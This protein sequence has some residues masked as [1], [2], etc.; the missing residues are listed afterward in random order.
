M[1]VKSKNDEEKKCVE[2]G[3]IYDREI[4]LGSQRVVVGTHDVIFLLT[5]RG[6]SQRNKI[7]LNYKFG[8]FFFNVGFNKVAIAL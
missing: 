8:R 5:K 6:K 1:N 7:R 4:F 3:D 2:C